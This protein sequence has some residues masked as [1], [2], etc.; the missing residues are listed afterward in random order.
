[1]RYLA[2]MKAASDKI[3]TTIVTLVL[4]I[5]ALVVIWIFLSGTMP[6]ITTAIQ[7]FTCGMCKAILPGVMEGMCGKC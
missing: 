3:I 7:K 6:A 1:M 5:I 4:A 2:S